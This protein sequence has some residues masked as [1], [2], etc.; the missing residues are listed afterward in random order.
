[1]A[2]VRPHLTVPT[3]PSA[4]PANVVTGDHYRIT[5]LDAG[6]IRLE[7]SPGGEFEDRPSQTVLNRDFP[8]TSYHLV[9]NDDEL[10]LHTERLHLVYDKQPFSAEGLAV[11]ARGGLT[12][13]HSVWRYGLP[14]E[15]LGGTARTLDMVDGACELEDGV[16]SRNGIAVVDD[17]ATLLLTE[18]GWVAPRIPGNVDVYV[19]GYGRDYREGLRAFHALTGKQPLLPRFALGNWWSRYHR[20]SAQEY[21]DLMDR[22]DREGLP[23]SVAVLDMDWHVTDVDPKHGSG[24]TGYTWNRELFPDPAGFLADLHRRD[25]RVTLNVHPADGVRA[26]EDAYE[27]T[28]ERLGID[29]ATELPVRFDPADPDFMSAYL[30]EVHHPLEEEG[31]DFW[32]VDWQS[33]SHSK[34]RGL[35][36]LWILNHL[37]YLDTGRDGRRPLTFSR[38]AGIGSHRYPVGFSGDAV[39]TWESLAFQPFFTATASNVGYGWWSHDVGGHLLG[40]KD[41]ELATRWVQFGV[42]SPLTRLHS[43]ADP[44]NSKEPWRFDGQAERVMRRFLRLRHQLVPYLYTMNRRAH[45]D[46][47]PLVQPMYYEHPWQEDAYR[48]TGQYLF[49]TE[50]LVAPVTEPADLRLRLGRVRTWLPEGT[51]VDFFTGLVYRGG[52]SAYLHRDLDSIP[53]LARAGAIVPMVPDRAVG[54]GTGNPAALELRVFAGA[55]GELTLWEDA[56][57]G[58][59][60][61]TTLRFD[62]DAAEVVV[63]ATEGD[64]S[65]LPERR[66]YDLVLVGFAGVDAAEVSAGG[67]AERHDVEPGPVPGSVLVRV[68]PV[69]VGTEVRV[70]LHGDT[71]LATNDVLSRVFGLLDRAQ[72]EFATK[73]EVWQVV[74]QEDPASAVL[75]LQSLDLPDGLLAAV[76]EILL[77]Q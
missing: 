4:D 41:D 18:D 47:E 51:W 23:F 22:F 60:A 25:L 73:G 44:F 16:L 34:L 75:S 59:W 7:Y 74:R 26:F 8:E 49:G 56:D 30:E 65:S 14:V 33:G 77:A 66:G 38:Y 54:N 12:S 31:V 21:A 52:R 28:A 35:D 61:A 72:I 29:P 11:Q 2:G 37:H 55:D 17:S 13:Y 39:T 68:G 36:P 45:V 71:A 46:D 57:D 19:F 69:S 70:R 5:V 76:S 9:E 40:V 67:A 62:A 3:R 64:L 6:L 63:G 15:N 58:R 20:Y 24:W 42:F 1:V 10:E 27:R 32:W 50:L 43:T 48:A 53:V